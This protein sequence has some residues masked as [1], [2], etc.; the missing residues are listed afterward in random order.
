MGTSA[1]AASAERDPDSLERED[2]SLFPACLLELFLSHISPEK[3][4]RFFCLR[5]FLTATDS[6]PILLL[7]ALWSDQQLHSSTK[8]KAVNC[9]CPN[10]VFSLSCNCHFDGDQVQ[11]FSLT[12][13]VQLNTMRTSTVLVPLTQINWTL[14]WFVSIFILYTKYSLS[15][16]LMS[17]THMHTQRIHIDLNRGIISRGRGIKQ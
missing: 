17:N 3:S 8:K 13:S 12:S 1:A 2:D 4:P 7:R 9:P 16:P 14:A 10:G 5:L 6:W 11:K 15:F